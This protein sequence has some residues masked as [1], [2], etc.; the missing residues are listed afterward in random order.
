MSGP[1]DELNEGSQQGLGGI[2]I[3][4]GR[5]ADVGGINVLRVLPTK[6]RRTVGPWCFVDLMHPGDVAEPPPIEIGPHP[7]IGL[8]TATWLFDGSVVH[9]DSLGT[10]QLIRPGELNLM[11][12][13]RGIAHAELGIETPDIPSGVLGAQMWIAQP[14][15]TR[16]GRNHFEHHA[17]LP[18]VEL[19][20]GHA[21][22]IV[23]SFSG[24]ASR[25]G[26]DHPAIGLDVTFEGS[27]EVPLRPSFEHA[28][29]PVDRQLKVEDALVD[30]G[31]LA[32]LP[33]GY[34]TLRVEERSG[35]A[36]MLLIG[37]KPFGVDVKMWW[38]FVART[39]EEI[40]DAWR[41]WR[42]HDDDR[43][44]PVS[45]KLGRVEAPSPPWIPA[46]G[47]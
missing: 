36:R 9:S 42:D 11:T 2:E 19:R 20:N 21:R 7:H 18:I 33:P 23:G 12:A 4:E 3:K 30:L 47:S 43:F 45:S 22:V 5:V 41:G 34:E 32:L 31:S 40:T 28:V 46:G 1:L 13:G 38:N 16:N 25:A 37:G 26:V 10:E 14:D 44:G 35:S 6:K 39:I 24:V 8:A 27:T 17:D 15:A 29:V